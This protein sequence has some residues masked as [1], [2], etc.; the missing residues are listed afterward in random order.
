MPTFDVELNFFMPGIIRKVNVPRKHLM[1]STKR[2]QLDQIF[3]F[4]QND[5]QPQELPSVSMGDVIRFKGERYMVLSIG[6]KKLKPNEY[7]LTRPKLEDVFQF[8]KQHE[9]NKNNKPNRE[10]KTTN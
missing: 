1:H 4:G 9:P 10:S 8:P 5:F 7:L 2:Q 6:F 3:R